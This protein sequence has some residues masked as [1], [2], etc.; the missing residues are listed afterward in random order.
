VI[1]EHKKGSHV[2][3]V[4]GPWQ[5]NANPILVSF[6]FGSNVLVTKKKK[7]KK[8]KVKHG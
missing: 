5:R 8:K 1:R 2:A 6:P 3:N 7:K 4:N